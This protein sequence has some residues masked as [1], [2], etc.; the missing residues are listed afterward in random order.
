MKKKERIFY[1][2]LLSYAPTY[3]LL[4]IGLYYQP[5]GWIPILCILT[6]TCTLLLYPVYRVF[7]DE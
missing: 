3:P 2:F 6:L 5:E 7:E 4:L 1:T